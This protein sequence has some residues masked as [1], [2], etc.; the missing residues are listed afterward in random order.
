[1]YIYKY[2]CLPVYLGYISI[3]SLS[4]DRRPIL[5]LCHQV[6]V[7][8]AALDAGALEALALVR[9]ELVL[10]RPQARA[11]LG[12]LQTLRLHVPDCSTTAVVVGTV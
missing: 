1:M 8:T 12:H 2:V 9:D 10:Q 3:F 5:G 11:T 4:S 6:V 7:E